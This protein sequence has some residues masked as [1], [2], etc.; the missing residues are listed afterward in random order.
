M[1]PVTEM[2]GTE[3]RLNFAYGSNLD[4]VEDWEGFCQERGFG[5]GLLLPVKPAVLPDFEL[6][7]TK[8]SS[9]REGGVLDIRPR[10]GCVTP[11]MLFEVRG[12]G[13]EALDAKE[14]A[15]SHYRRQ[16]VTVLT[17]DNEEVP[18]V[19]YRVTET[20]GSVDASPSYVEV[21]R[22]GLAA[23]R[24]DTGPLE[25][26]VAKRRAGA[27]DAL[28]VYGTLM[29]GELRYPALGMRRPQC[30]LLARTLGRLIHLGK[31][32]GFVQEGDGE[33]CGDLVR[34]A[35][36]EP[37]LREVDQVEGFGGWGQRDNLYR[38]ILI[39]AD[40]GDGDTHPAW[41]YEYQGDGP[42]RA[43]ASGCWR[44][45]T[46]CSE[47]VFS[48]IAAG[49]GDPD[50]LLRKMADVRSIPAKGFDEFRARHTPLWAALAEWRLSEQDLAQ[51]SGRRAVE[52]EL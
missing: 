34:F 41:S 43:I 28:F 10:L 19:A 36:V 18:A 13:W 4:L 9:K 3:H 1:P 8:Y 29:R 33:V 50:E 5:T 44:H 49:H 46:G 12:E 31:F 45:A 42:G 47:E 17:R 15:P 11:G 21:V 26:A 52:I 7:F 40:V 37:V 32:P 16:P 2:M 6:A 22:R 39:D 20:Q 35:D 23:F 24:L 25:D 30:I 27:L 38:R 14:G 48:A 51:A